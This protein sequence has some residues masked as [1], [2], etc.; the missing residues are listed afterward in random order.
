VKVF[1]LAINDLKYSLEKLIDFLRKSH[2]VSWANDL[3]EQYHKIL[4]AIEI[5]DL[6]GV[7]KY[8]ETITPYF[9]GM[10]SLNDI[11]ICRANRNVP[12]GLSGIMA[13]RKLNKMLDDLFMWCFFWN[14]ETNHAKKIY[15]DYL[16]THPNDL[17][18][19]MSRSVK[20]IEAF[21]K[22]NKN[23]FSP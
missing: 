9:G 8:I 2:E 7:E 11:V 22:I 15:A 20:N 18:P 5:K 19:R 13:N 16:R 14:I 23:S 4:K 3:E 17:P 6:I 21:I 1:K 12:R 10:G